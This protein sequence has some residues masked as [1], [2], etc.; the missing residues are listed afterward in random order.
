MNLRQRS[1]IGIF[2]VL[3]TV[4]GMVWFAHEISAQ[5]LIAVSLMIWGNNLF[6][7]LRAVEKASDLE[8]EPLPHESTPDPLQRAPKL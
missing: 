6:Q 5:A 4:T 8:G 2:G 3:I 7:E 1:W